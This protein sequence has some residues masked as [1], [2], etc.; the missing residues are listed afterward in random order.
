[1]SNK[2]AIRIDYRGL[3]VAQLV[4]DVQNGIAAMLGIDRSAIPAATQDMIRKT[5]H[6]M[7]VEGMRDSALRRFI[8]GDL[9]DGAKPFH[10]FIGTH[11][12]QSR[13]VIHACDFLAAL[14]ARKWQPKDA[15]GKKAGKSSK[16][17]VD[18]PSVDVP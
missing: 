10:G 5:C 1:M 3:S 11:K 14:L 6:E 18:V 15:S 9:T 17:Q 13:A 16:Q 8:D 4:V 7:G 2:D 12:P